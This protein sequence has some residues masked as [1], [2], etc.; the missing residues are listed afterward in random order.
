[1]Q[2]VWSWIVAVWCWFTPD[3]IIAMATF[4]YAVTTI[5]TFLAIRRQ[6]R[7]FMNAERAHVDVDLISVGETA[8][9]LRVLNNGRS[10]AYLKICTRSD[11]RSQD[12]YKTDFR[13][14]NKVV[15]RLV[16]NE[17]LPVGEEKV[18]VMKFNFSE[19]VP[20]AEEKQ[21]IRVLINYDDSFAKSHETEVVY[22]YLPL[23]EGR[24][25]K[26]RGFGRYT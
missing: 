17:L 24:F 1:M 3:K 10:P 22:E 18:S 9:D 8:W 4:V 5:V 13:G 2:V 15:Y 14:K 7:A 6:A 21:V 20:G 16:L 25:S 12:V 11:Y 23:P 19:P 26:L